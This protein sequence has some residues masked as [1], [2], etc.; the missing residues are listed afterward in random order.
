MTTLFMLAV[1]MAMRLVD[2]RYLKKG[3]GI[4]VVTGEDEETGLSG[5]AITGIIFAAAVVLSC[6]I[7]CFKV[8]LEDQEAKR[9]FAAIQKRNQEFEARTKDQPPAA[10]KQ[11]P[12][13]YTGAQV[14]QTPQQIRA[15][16]LAKFKTLSKAQAPTKPVPSPIAVPPQ[17][18][19]EDPDE[20]ADEEAC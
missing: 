2:G 12:A 14:A 6:L 3:G 4:V 11:S 20:E 17:A 13:A 16:E 19:M 9:S 7:G 10:R 5:G 18:P 8:V 1:L 15:M